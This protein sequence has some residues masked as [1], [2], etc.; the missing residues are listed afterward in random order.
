MRSVRYSKTFNDQLADLIEYGERRYGQAIAEAKQ[1]LVFSTVESYL[2]HFPGAKRADES[3]GLTVHS[4]P[5]T[6]FMILFDYD[7]TELRVHFVFYK[8]ADMTELDPGSVEW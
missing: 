2:S 1:E 6:P 8:S 7:D 5:K 4:V 3:L